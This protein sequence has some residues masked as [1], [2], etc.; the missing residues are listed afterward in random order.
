MAS[1]QNYH[2]FR[3]RNDFPDRYQKR[4]SSSEWKTLKHTI[5]DHRGN[6]CERC[7]IESSSL[8]LHHLHYNS[9]GSEKPQDVELLC[10]A[11]H[12]GADDA[13]QAK[14]RPK[15]EIIEEGLIVGENGDHRGLLAPDT[16]Y[17][18]LEDGRYLPLISKRKSST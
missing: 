13:R 2:L 4:I 10:Q 17:I 3:G 6:R 7:A 11:C 5:I 15:R 14:N 8:E 12:T 9:L 16:I 18:P 1:A